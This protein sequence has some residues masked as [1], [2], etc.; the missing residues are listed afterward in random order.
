MLS[1]LKQKKLLTILIN[2]CV[3]VMLCGVSAV[4]MYTNGIAGI[5]STY[6]NKKEETVNKENKAQGDYSTSMVST[7][8]DTVVYTTDSSNAAA[9]IEDNSSLVGYCTFY[10]YVVAPY[11]GSKYKPGYRKYPE[12]SIN[13]A[14]NYADNG[15]PKLTVG[16][17]DQNY[18][19][20]RYSCMVNGLN[21]NNCIYYNDGKYKTIGTF[22]GTTHEYYLA[23]QGIIKSL[24]KNDYRKVIF[25]VDEPGLFSDEAKTGKTVIKDYKLVFDKKD[26][27]N[28]S[29]TYTLDYVLS[30]KGNKTSAG[31]K[32][33]PLND[34]E[35]NVLDAGYG[36]ASGKIGTNY[37]FGMRYD[38][39]FAL[40]GYD[41]DLLYKFTGDDDLWVFLD[42]E[43]VLDLGG[44]HP[45]CGGDVDLWKVGPLADELRAAGGIKTEVDQHKKH[46]ITVLYMERGGNL[47][48]CN[49]KFIVP[50]SARIITIDDYDVDKT[51]T[52]NDWENRTYDVSLGAYIKNTEGVIL[53]DI[54]NVTVRDYIDN[55]FNIID[56]EGKIVTTDADYAK[57]H[58]DY[59]CVT[60]EN[61]LTASGGTIGYDTEKN[62]VYVEWVDQTVE[63]QDINGKDDTDI[64]T[65]S[66]DDI[67]YGWKK[68]IQ[69]KAS[70]YYAG[71]NNITT[72]GLD[73]GVTV[74]GQFKE[75]PRP[76]VNVR[77]IPVI[78]NIEDVIFYG[79]SFSDYSDKPEIL[80]K[81]LETKGC[82]LSEDG[83][84]LSDED[85]T[86]SWYKDDK[87][88][89]ELDVAKAE[90]D[91]DTAYKIKVKYAV[92]RV[93]E[94]DMCTKNSKG[95]IADEV[96]YNM[97]KDINDNYYDY[98][99]YTIHVVKGQLDIT[100]CID[101]QY[102][103]NKIIRANQTYVFRIEQYEYAN[104][105]KTAQKGE[106]E[107]V[108]YQ[109]VSFDAN[110]DIIKKTATVRGLRKGF[111]TVTEDADWTLEYKLV[112][113]S[114]NYDGNNNA[115]GYETKDIFIG[116]NTRKADY[117]N[118]IRPEFYGLDSTH[119]GYIADGEPA[120]TQFTNNKESGFRWLSDAASAINRFIGIDE[121][122]Q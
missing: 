109:P 121:V 117:A 86:V 81:V 80:R 8:S 64:D 63:N 101:E 94:N 42:G 47:S 56:D 52:L 37:Y 70:P 49:M 19:Q 69:V 112:N 102:T 106:L 12:K 119:Y 2:I 107:A 40:N 21:A 14:D 57:E 13:T 87:P 31:D 53:K 66:T 10:D 3:V 104:I 72:N 103:D 32:F 26:N 84:D 91:S 24:D 27:G 82:T 39:E 122:K 46:I 61:T 25:N 65:G 78:K 35:S 93:D 89:D 59:V 77:T 29:S 67:K 99:V 62:M 95:H 41:D 4:I 38:V 7:A 100:K 110:G 74:N 90:P 98:A 28:R 71:G 55:R 1:R 20:N 88:I 97:E 30:P 34:S 116:E 113:M 22:D 68:I 76:T 58:D 11:K 92:S 18:S 17:T 60:Q 83:T 36:G 105:D 108:F 73:S 115:G 6:G 43:L 16:T 44:I 50:D 23:T 45:E 120:Q 75:F 5:A 79:D 51:V 96:L 118:N 114:D 48:N 54:T 85:F 9:D 15:K 33:F 111:Y